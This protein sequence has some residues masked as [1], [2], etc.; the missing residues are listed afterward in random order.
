MSLSEFEVLM[1]GEKVSVLYCRGV[2]V[3]KRRTG[4]LTRL[5]YQLES[6]YVEVIYSSYRSCIDTIVCSGSTT[7]VDPYLDQINI[8]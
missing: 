2:Y 1:E 3:G 6:F 8:E 4:R 5:L 7:M